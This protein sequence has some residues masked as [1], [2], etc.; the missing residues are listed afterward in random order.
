MK[1]L[2]FSTKARADLVAIADFIAAD[3]PIRASRFVAALRERCVSLTLHPF[4]GRP[5]PEIDAQARLLV[6]RS[7]VVL[8]RVVDERIEIIRVL[9]GAQDRSLLTLNP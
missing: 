3:D 1:S 7:Y 5:A 4:Q 2:V 6:F 8:H 9:H